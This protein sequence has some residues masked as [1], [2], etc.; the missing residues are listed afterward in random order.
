MRVATPS[1]PLVVT[2]RGTALSDSMRET[3]DANVHA[4][5]Q[6]VNNQSELSFIEMVDEAM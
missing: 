2:P 3:L 5:C 1:T 6:P 4:Q